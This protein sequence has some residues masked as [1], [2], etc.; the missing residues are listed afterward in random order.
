M[1]LENRLDYMI[2]FDIFT[3]FFCKNVNQSINKDQINEIMF[4]WL[5]Y[6]VVNS[7]NKK[8][9]VKWEKNWFEK[10][11]LEVIWLF[12]NDYSNSILN[13]LLFW[14]KIHFNQMKSE[15]YF[16]FLRK[17]FQNWNFFFAE[18]ID[19]ICSDDF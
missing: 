15:I 1:I 12:S 18:R 2:Q 6:V 10:N 3:K 9:V 16:F 13:L 4:F 17:I 11:N 14:N 7:I 5:S 8:F 19:F